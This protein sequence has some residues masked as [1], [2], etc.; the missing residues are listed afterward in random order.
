MTFSVGCAGILV[1]DSLCGPIAALPGPGELLTLDDIPARAGGCAANVAID[2]AR[3]D[4]D[5]SI[6][7]CVGGD[8]AAEVPLA[9]LREHGVDC[10]GIARVQ[11]RRP[12]RRSSCWSKAKTAATSTRSAPMRSSPS[13]IF[14]AIGSSG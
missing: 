12:A 7:G 8:A 11:G 14:A 4:F 10:G 1:A 6:V 5:V 9:A 2:L 3:Q 13:P